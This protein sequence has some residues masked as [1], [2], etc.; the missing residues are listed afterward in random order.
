MK[1]FLF[2][3]SFTAILLFSGCS[4]NKTDRDEVAIGPGMMELDL[5]QYGLN[6]SI[7]VPDSTIG[8][9][10]VTAQSYGD[11]EIRVGTYFQIKIAPGGD[12]ALK[13]NDLESDLLFKTTIIKEE[14]DLIIYRSDLPDGSKSYHHFYAI[15]KAGE[16]IYEIRDIEESGESFS[17]AIISKMVE[18]AR[19]LKPIS[20]ES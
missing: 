5:S 1:N 15:V 8:T 12:L 13:K 19:S 6:L 14:P 16:A 17:E 7:M 11:M 9:L 2:L 18:A 4:S 10:E 20:K 3:F